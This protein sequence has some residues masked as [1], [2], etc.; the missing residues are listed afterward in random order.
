MSVFCSVWAGV[1]MIDLLRQFLF[2]VHLIE[3]IKNNKK[4]HTS[5]QQQ[6]GCK[7]LKKNERK[8]QYAT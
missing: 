5:C 6:D 8:N 7:Y 4:Y 2:Q 3:K 1:L